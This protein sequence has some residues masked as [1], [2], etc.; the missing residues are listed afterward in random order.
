MEKTN[1]IYKIKLTTITPVAIGDGGTLSPLSDYIY[2]NGK[3]YLI[4][5]KEFEG[6]IKDV[7]EGE[8]GKTQNKAII[9]EFVESVSSNDSLRKFIE[10]NLD[11]NF[12]KVCFDPSPVFG[13]SS[14]KE[15]KT[16]IKNGNQPYISGSTIKG[17]IKGALFYYLLNQK[18]NNSVLRV[19]TFSDKVLAFRDAW[20]LN[21]EFSYLDDYLFGISKNGKKNMSLF[22]VRDTELI[23]INSLA[24]YLLERS[25]VVRRDIEGKNDKD[26]EVNT[27]NFSNE[28]NEQLLALREQ[29]KEQPSE[30]VQDLQEYVHSTFIL[31]TIGKKEEATFEILINKSKNGLDYI[32][33]ALNFLQE[34]EKAML[35]L[36][37]KINQFSLALINQEIEDVPENRT[38]TFEGYISFLS[39]Q[40]IRI[41]EAIS[42][43]QTC[44]LRIGLGKTY[45]YSSIGLAIKQ[46]DE[47]AFQKLR[48]IMNLRPD[49]NLYPKTRTL[50]AE[51]QLPLGWV[52]LEYQP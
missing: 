9:D 43:N 34:E 29:L 15:I 26:V 3:I 46:T 39:Q 36:F 41:E 6:L 25:Y 10:E 17:A 22:K 28:M 16:C 8:N 51:T 18:G 32:D 50:L 7:Y 40:K 24:F 4:N 47:E 52:K 14:S 44:Y 27:S 1:S 19:K 49:Q 48:K 11:V 31:E 33:G 45:F 2:D 12:T 13:T 20:N 5:H 38:E 21:E 30:L 23:N 35:S 37:E 42:T